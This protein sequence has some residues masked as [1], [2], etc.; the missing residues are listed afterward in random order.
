[1]RLTRF[2][3]RGR[4]V[5]EVKKLING[6]EFPDGVVKLNP[7]E[8]KILKFEAAPDY[9]AEKGDYEFSGVVFM[10][11]EYD[12][13]GCGLS[14]QVDFKP[15]KSHVTFDQG[16]PSTPLEREQWETTHRATMSS[17]PVKP[18]ATFAE[19][20]LYRAVRLTSGG[21]RSLQLTP[22]KAGDV[23][24]T[25]DVKMPMESGHGIDIN[26]PVQWIWEGSAPIRTSEYSTEYVDGTQHVCGVGT[27]CPRSGR[28]VARIRIEDVRF[29]PQYRYDTT[30]IVTMRR[31]QKMPSI[32]TSARDA[33]W[34]WVGA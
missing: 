2:A 28:W 11:I 31:D 29:V 22:F 25:S 27:P 14:S 12:G 19:D 26:G 6:S 18:G 20:G 7:G 23:A 34:E 3:D 15:I 16:Y 5:W 24:T 21:Y 13:Y 32:R 1:M 4:L 8:A 17:Q 30:Q 9:K 33:D 10:R